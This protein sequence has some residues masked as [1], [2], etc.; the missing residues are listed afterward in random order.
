M[1]SVE[2]EGAI[3]AHPDVVEAAVI[4]RPDPRWMERPVAYVVLREGSALGAG[5]LLAHLTPMV[6]KWWLPD[7]VVFVPA[8]PKTGTGKISKTALRDSARAG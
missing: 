6:A 7:E 5:E 2:L 1:Y 3:T 4:A 8:L